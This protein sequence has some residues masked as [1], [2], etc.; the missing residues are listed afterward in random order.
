MLFGAGISLLIDPNNLAPGGVSG[1][2]IIL[3]RVIPIETG[4]LFFII[5]V[6]IM[7]IGWQKFGWKFILSTLYAIVLVSLFS[8]FFELFD[9]LTNQPIL[10]ALFGGA[11]TA[12][13]MGLVLRNGTTTGGTDIIVKCIKKKI[14]YVKTSTL[15][16]IIDTIIICLGGLVFGNIDAVLYSALCATVTSQVIDL[17]LYGR[18]EAKLIYIISDT[19]AKIATRIMNEVHSGVTYLSGKGAYKQDN[20]Q[21]ILCVVKKQSA[22][23]VEEIVRQEDA[24]AFMII[25]RATEIYGEGYKSYFG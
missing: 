22:P 11:L 20:K 3:N 21:I 23:K 8:N 17:V 24:D 18:D 15:L 2:A 1:L 7:I 9:P 25:T 6:P 4:T 5:N 12:L 13:G 14:P 10:G 19:W 16:L